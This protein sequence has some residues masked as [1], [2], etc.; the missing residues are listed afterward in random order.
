VRLP[1]ALRSKPK[2]AVAVLLVTLPA[3]VLWVLAL[4]VAS[5]LDWKWLEQLATLLL[6][7]VWLFNLVMGVVYV[8]GSLSGRYDRLKERD[9]DHQV[10]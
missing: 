4:Q 9:W 6:V 1:E 10:W 8:S 7:C 5:A 3:V 2:S